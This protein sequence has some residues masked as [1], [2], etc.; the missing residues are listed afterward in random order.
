MKYLRTE[1]QRLYYNK[2]ISL[3]RDQHMGKTK[4]AKI[5]PVSDWTISNWIRK[6][7]A[8]T[9][10]YK[11]MRMKKAEEKRKQKAIEESL[12]SVLPNDKQSLRSEVTRLRKALREMSMRA[13]LYDEMINVAEKQFNISIRKKA[14]TK[15]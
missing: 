9:P 7:V 15:Q 5:I 1:K 14:G 11:S 6:F 3:Y 8:E 4:I 13:D 10:Q 12:Q 2:V